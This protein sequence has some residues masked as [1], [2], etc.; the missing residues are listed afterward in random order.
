[1][2][3][4]YFFKKRLVHF[5]LHCNLYVYIVAVL[6]VVSLKFLTMYIP[7]FTNNDHNCHSGILIH[8]FNDLQ[9][10]ASAIISLDICITLIKHIGKFEK[11]KRKPS[12]S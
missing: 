12:K 11:N 7:N 9:T 6:N 5:R 3:L 10:S 1:M 2:L 8:V 4:Q